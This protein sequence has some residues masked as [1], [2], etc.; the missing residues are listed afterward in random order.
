MTFPSLMGNATTFSDIVSAKDNRNFN[1][2][3]AFNATPSFLSARAATLSGV[4]VIHAKTLMM[5]MIMHHK[6]PLAA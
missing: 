2:Q 3:T 5:E 6:W 1:L 4:S